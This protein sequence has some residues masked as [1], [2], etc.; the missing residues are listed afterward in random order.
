MTLATLLSQ[1]ETSGLP[2]AYDHFP[3]KACPNPPFAVFREL[4][5]NNFGADDKVHQKIRRIEV[6]LITIGKDEA[7]EAALEETLSFTFWNQTESYTEDEK[8]W[9]TF[10]EI[11]ILGG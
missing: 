7:S 3:A 8:T 9:S 10:Y 6:E 5:T 4:G 11:E 1:L 2:V